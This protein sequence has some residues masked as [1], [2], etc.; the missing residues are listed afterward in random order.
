MRSVRDIASRI[1]QY[2]KP[3]KSLVN[4][5]VENAKRPIIITVIC[6]LGVIGGLMTVPLIFS[7]IARGI[8]AWYPP[9]LALSAVIGLICMIGLWQMKKWAA[10][11]YTGFAACGQV[12]MLVMGIWSI[13]SLLIPGIIV[14]I[15][16]ANVSKM[17]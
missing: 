15:V 3:E 4:E 6:V 12:A 14:V 10:Y 7:P 16:L 1:N 17:T 8:G 2:T 13:S 11:T 9:F 5:I